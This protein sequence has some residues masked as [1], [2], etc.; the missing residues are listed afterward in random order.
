MK[1]ATLFFQGVDSKDREMEDPT[2]RNIVVVADQQPK[3]RITSPEEELEVDRK[4][5]VRFEYHAEDDYGLV[6]LE[7]FLSGEEFERSISLEKPQRSENGRNVRT[8]D[9]TLNS[10]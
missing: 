3:V 1:E 10:P 2:T 9:R 8:T 6:G 4:S 7:L 5:R